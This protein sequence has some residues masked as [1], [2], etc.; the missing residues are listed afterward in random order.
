RRGTAAVGRF[1]GPVMIVWFVA[2]GALGVGGIARDPEIL[3]ALSPKNSAAPKTPRAA[4]TIE[5][6]RVLGTAHLRISVMSA[7]MPPSP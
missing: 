1:F 6:W 7:M 3:R 4:R 2:I 5:V